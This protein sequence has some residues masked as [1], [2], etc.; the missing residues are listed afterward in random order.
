MRDERIAPL[1]A[2]RRI[3]EQRYTQARVLFVAGSV[4]RGQGTPASDPDVVAI[5]EHLPDAYRESLVLETMRPP[6][7]ASL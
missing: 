4:L 2:A 1:E 7:S 5:Y 3:L 6:P